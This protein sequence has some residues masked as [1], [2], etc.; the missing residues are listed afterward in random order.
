MRLC[1]I[2]HCVDIRDFRDIIRDLCDIC[3]KLLFRHKSPFCLF[4][5]FD[6]GFMRR[7]I[8]VTLICEGPLRWLIDTI[9]CNNEKDHSGDFVT[10]RKS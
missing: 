5:V 7:T 2:M 8:K 6:V 10:V 4:T 1:I 9:S 3:L